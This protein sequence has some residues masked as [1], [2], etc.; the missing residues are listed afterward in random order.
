[1]VDNFLKTRKEL[2]VILEYQSSEELFKSLEG[3]FNV[4]LRLIQSR[5][6]YISKVDIW[7]YLKIKKWSH[8]VDLTIAEMVNDI[9]MVDISLVDAF[10]KEHLKNNDR[11]LYTN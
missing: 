6:D 9:M 7:N 8:D 5:Y 3:A 2:V 1:V 4:K 10:L 11:K